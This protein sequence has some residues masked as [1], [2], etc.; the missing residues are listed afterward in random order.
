MCSEV[1]VLLGLL[2]AFIP[3]DPAPKL[4]ILNNN[5]YACLKPYTESLKAIVLFGVLQHSGFGLGDIDDGFI[6]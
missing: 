6:A 2:R 5:P 1:L 3:A 4:R